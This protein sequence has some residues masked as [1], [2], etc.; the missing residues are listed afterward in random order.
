MVANEYYRKVL[1]C[2]CKCTMM[3]EESIL[4][5]NKEACVDA[6]YVL[7][8]ILSQRFTDEEIANLSGLSRTCA[9]KIRNSFKFKYKKFS[10]RCI[11]EEVTNEL[12]KIGW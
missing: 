3:D 12:H 11:M 7:V 8:H 10:V 9:N 1:E 5:S 6:R 4:K 2:V